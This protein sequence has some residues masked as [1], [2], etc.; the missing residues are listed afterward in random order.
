VKVAPLA[1]DVNR[2]LDQ[3]DAMIGAREPDGG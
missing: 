3:R 1:A 2:L